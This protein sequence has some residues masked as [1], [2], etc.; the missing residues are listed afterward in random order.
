[1]I[2]GI[3]GDC[4]SSL[5]G[6]GDNEGSGRDFSVAFSQASGNIVLLLNSPVT[7]DKSVSIFNSLGDKVQDCV[8]STQKTELASGNLSNGIYVAQ[9]NS[10]EGSY[11]KKFIL[12]R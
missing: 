10:D 12:L 6:I 11:R 2:T 9:L 4:Q 1:T 3:T 7:R 8:I 5:T